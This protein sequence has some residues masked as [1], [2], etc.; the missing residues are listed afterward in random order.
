ESCLLGE[1]L[2]KTEYYVVLDNTLYRTASPPEMLIQARGRGYEAMLLATWP[3]TIGQ[4][5]GTSNRGAW[6]VLDQ[7][8]VDWAEGQAD[9]CTHLRRRSTN[10]EE[11]IWFC[12]G[13]GIVKHVIRESGE[14]IN[15]EEK[16][17]KARTSAARF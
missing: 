2:E 7:S 14:R 13:L 5:F 3:A 10:N 1:Q 15:A 4:T 12:E 16:S 8:P 11:E 17:L 9:G 6:R